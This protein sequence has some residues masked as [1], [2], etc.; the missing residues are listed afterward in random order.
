MT[1]RQPNIIRTPKDADHPFLAISRALA[2]DTR[3]SYEARGVLLYLLSK[4]SSWQVRP[5]DLEIAGCRRDKVYSILKELKAAGYLVREQQRADDGTLE[6]LPYRV[7]EQ[8]LPLTEY[9]EVVERIATP[10]AP[11]TEYTEVVQP[12]TLL[13]DTVKPYVVSR[14]A[15]R[16][17]AANGTRREKQPHTCLPDTV[18]P[19]V[20]IIENKDNREEEEEARE[21]ISHTAT[22]AATLCNLP[23]RMSSQQAAS[24]GAL[25]A[26]LQANDVP[27]E[28]LA[29][30]AAW[31]QTKSY[32]ARL[33]AKERRQ[34]SPP[35]PAQV[36]RF[37]PEFDTPAPAD[38]YAAYQPPVCA[39]PDL[40][41]PPAGPG[42]AAEYRRRQAAR[43]AALAT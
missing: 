35:S 1:P 6:W 21:I 10:S 31:W 19:H 34:V 14:G 15:A 36:V 4:P 18:K 2:Q 26:F 8:P 27:V 25:V 30:F 33:A 43:Q 7:M 39:A 42:I 37:W 40:N 28:K 9:T 3:L 41:E 17:D 38:V 29:A 16:Q 11:H 20:Y 12:H 13:P 32:P 22:T 23:E 24:L 5:A